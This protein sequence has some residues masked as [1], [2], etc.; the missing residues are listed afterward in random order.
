L[1]E[2]QSGD[3]FI[4]M[5]ATLLV[6]GHTDVLN[7]IWKIVASIVDEMIMSQATTSDHVWIVEVYQLFLYCKFVSKSA[8]MS[9]KIAK[10][11]GL[12]FHHVS[13]RKFF[14]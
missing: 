9:G 5:Y 10:T 11:R 12:K 14:V 1:K 3:G 4:T 13:L 7:H 6:P 8:L 2:E